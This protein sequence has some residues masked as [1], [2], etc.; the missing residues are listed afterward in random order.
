MVYNECKQGVNMNCSGCHYYKPSPKGD[1]ALDDFVC[2]KW[3]KCP[4][5]YDGDE[6][7]EEDDE[8]C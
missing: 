6:S 5:G 7:E 3:S 1:P 2:W 8:N 4:Y